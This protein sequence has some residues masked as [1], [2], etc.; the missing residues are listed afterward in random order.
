MFCKPGNVQGT[1]KKNT[2]DYGLL[3]KLTARV[4]SA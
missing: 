4:E 3:L 1:K 2:K